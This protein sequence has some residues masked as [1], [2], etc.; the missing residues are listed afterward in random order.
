MSR[1]VASPGMFRVILTDR[2]RG[3]ERVEVDS[4]FNN[5]RDAICR[6]KDIADV[7]AKAEVFNDEG[8]WVAS[9]GPILPAQS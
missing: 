6:A 1:L 4:E 7:E 8:K 2:F 9:A 3:E 5:A